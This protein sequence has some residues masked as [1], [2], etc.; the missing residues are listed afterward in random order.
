MLNRKRF[1][2]DPF[3]TQCE[4]RGCERPPHDW[5]DTDGFTFEVC[6]QHELELRAGEPH[7]TEAD[8]IVAGSDCTREVLGVTRTRTE[9]SET[10]IIKLGHEGVIYQEV[11]LHPDVD[12]DSA[13]HALGVR[14]A[15]L[16]G[17][18]SEN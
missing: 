18:R 7:S 2:T 1:D 6:A 8:E 13:L 16:Q 17:D 15:D 11:H 9:T 12:L 10:T 3:P 5:F 4:V 14:G